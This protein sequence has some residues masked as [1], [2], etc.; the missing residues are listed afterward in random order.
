M[1]EKTLRIFQEL[2]NEYAHADLTE[3]RSIVQT[4]R[5]PSGTWSLATIGTVVADYGHI[6][7]DYSRFAARLVIEE[8]YNQTSSSFTACCATIQ[9]SV[10]SITFQENF[11]DFIAKYE[12]EIED[13]IDHTRDHQYD[14]FGYKTLERAYLL[15]VDDTICERP[16]YMWMRVA[17]AIHGGLLNGPASNIADVLQTYHMMSKG[18]FTHAT[19][20]LFN[21]GLQNGQLSS[22][23]LTTID[24]DSIEG[25]YQ[26]LRKC[27][28][29][30]KHA[31]GIGLNIHNVRAKGSFIKGTGGKS[32]G[33][34]PMLRVFNETARYVDQGGGK[35]K[36][37]I[38]VYLEPWHADILAFL[39]L[40]KNTG[41][42]TE[43]AR[44]LFQGLWICDLFMH[45]V[46]E[47]KAWT[48]FCPTDVPKLIE[49]WGVPFTTQYISYE[50]DRTIPKHTISA[51]KIW[52]TILEAQMET[53]M[54][55]MLYK[56]TC[57]RLS[58]QQH[59]G[60]IKGSNL[61]T[62]II[63]YSSPSETAVCNLASIA[64]PKFALSRTTIHPE[65][66][67]SVEQIKH[68]QTCYDFQ[69]LKETASTIC[70]N[71]NNII[72][73]SYYP[74][75]E[76]RRSNMRHRPMGIGVQGWSDSL[77]LLGIAVDSTLAHQWNKLV[78]ETIYFGACSRSA[79]LAVH[80][81]PYPAF[82]GSPMSTGKFHFDMITSSPILSGL[83][84]WDTLRTQIQTTGI[85]NSLL[86]APMPTAST[87]QI[88]G[89]SEAF[90]VRQSNIMVRRTLAGEYVC[91]N[92]YMV[93]D[94]ERL[95][96]W[97]L[98]LCKQIIAENGSIQSMMAIPAYIRDIYKTVWEVSGKVQANHAIG[99]S[100]FIDQSQSMSVFMESPSVQK[101]TALHFYTW[102]GGLKTGLYYLRT[103]PARQAI[104]FTVKPTSN[105][106][107]TVVTQDEYCTRTDGCVS[108]GS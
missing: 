52:E 19:P 107:K 100:P 106:D 9:S 8:L 91:V 59:C 63:Q 30:S 94:L 1:T 20:T 75:E 88:L 6:H 41:A 65:F 67:D 55:Y 80:M 96:L 105:S 104:K 101:L 78:F 38:A 76:A 81:S 89:N 16:Q 58:N 70:H 95:G 26:T 12:Q 92:K 4:T 13:A 18:M 85:R 49:T 68:L 23:F 3:I 43:R 79:E 10:S 66:A 50:K 24:S 36:G 37:S 44:D 21:A 32:N 22:C 34:V 45:R 97:S 102:R 69:A 87:S 35:R 53:G 71:L 74:T 82:E 15:R 77:A 17:V 57:N 11:L 93:Q 61:C 54:P 48:L 73:I 98:E 28:H 86:V 29:I 83:W 27:A 2:G 84:D 90:H 42:E 7:P 108:C 60:T 64:L 33:I 99:R 72:D 46:Q 5:P 31:G 103:Q 51:R 25:I 39:D 62:E 47:D 40:R 14:Y 56:D